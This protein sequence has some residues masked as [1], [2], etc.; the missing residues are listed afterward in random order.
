MIPDFCLTE[1]RQIIPWTADYQVEQD[2]II[3]RALVNLYQN[4]KIKNTLAFRGGTALH[5]LYVNP[6]ARYSED[7]DLVQI[8]PAPIGETI[9]EIRTSLSWLGEPI[10]KLT[11]RGP[12]LFYRYIANDNSKMKLKIE[13]NTKEHFHL[14]NFVDYEFSITN[15][16]FSGQSALCTY[17]L[18]E[19]MG[20]KLRALYQRRKDRDLF[21]LWAVLKDNK[22][23]PDIVVKVFLAH[24]NREGQKITRALFE[25]NLHEK[26]NYPDF[27]HD[28]LSLITS[29]NTWSFEQAY[30]IVQDNL[31]CLLPGESWRRKP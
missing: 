22:V 12:K 2:L 16:W 31:I 5:K 20:T 7:I 19:L 24:C 29:D 21:D 23:D 1:W 3:S 4:P 30:E 17:Q 25:K 11:E 9:N 14:F 6:P 15:S 18:N 8:A 13:I 10:R 26:I 28:I 27:Q